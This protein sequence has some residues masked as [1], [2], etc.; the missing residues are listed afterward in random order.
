MQI[1]PFT[2]AHRGE[3][4]DMMRTFFHSPAVSTDGSEEIFAANVDNCLRGTPYVEG[5]VFL[6]GDTVMGYSILAKSYATEFGRF[7]VWVEDIYLK[8]EYRSL[9][10]GDR[11]FSYIEE[12][13]PDA[14]FRLEAEEEN[15]GAVAFYRRHGYT[16][17][18]Y[19]EMKK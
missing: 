4:I 3:I 18:P 7:C 6:E 14:V 19:L 15:T 17:L 1:S 12:K 13:Y 11:F 9:G 16:T 10:I 2:A 8:P 5:Y